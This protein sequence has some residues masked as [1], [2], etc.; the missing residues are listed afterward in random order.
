MF[1]GG[2]REYARVCVG[3]CACA[4]GVCLSAKNFLRKLHSPQV[5]RHQLCLPELRLRS[6]PYVT[7]LES[8]RF[9]YSARLMPSSKF[10]DC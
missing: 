8:L 5:A 6:H 4:V 10:D 1:S 7:L 9:Q 3:V 2:F